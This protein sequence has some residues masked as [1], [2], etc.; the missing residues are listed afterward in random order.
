M[1]SALEAQNN[2]L[3]HFACVFLIGGKTPF[4]NAS[5]CWPTCRLSGAGGHM[6]GRLEGGRVSLKG[7]SVGVLVCIFVWLSWKESEGENAK[8]QNF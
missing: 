5:T 3:N 6:K 7:A 2:Y 1:K 4:K 8:G